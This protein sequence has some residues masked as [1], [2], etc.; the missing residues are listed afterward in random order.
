MPSGKHHALTDEAHRK[1]LRAIAVV[2]FVKGVISM[3]LLFGLFS[4]MRRHYD[5]AQAAQ[6]LLYHLRISPD[7]HLSHAFIDIAG[8]VR[9]AS[10]KIVL[11]VILLYAGMRF[12]ESFGLWFRRVWGEWFTLFS[13]LLFLPLEIRA[14]VRQ[15]TGFHW[16]VLISNLV[17]VG[18]IGAI[19]YHA[20]QKRK[21]AV[22]GDLSEEAPDQ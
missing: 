14:I 2:E 16:L 3:V 20:H 7:H 17:I 11:L 19:R 13:C 4:L 6:N 22:A 1:G 5:L 21:A 10:L 18:Y 8:R 15:P 12:V 9:G